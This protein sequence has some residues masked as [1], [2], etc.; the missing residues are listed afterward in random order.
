MLEIAA[1]DAD[2]TGGRNRRQARQWQREPERPWS[3]LYFNVPTQGLTLTLRV[4]TGKSSAPL[5][6]RV[7]DRSYGLPI[8]NDFCKP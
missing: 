7:I 5:T 1:L 4:R 6:L 8:F 3:L 2:I